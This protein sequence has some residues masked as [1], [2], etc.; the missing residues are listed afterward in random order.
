VAL[1][2]HLST[3]ALSSI[4][5][6]LN[7]EQRSIPLPFDL[8]MA[9]GVAGTS[10]VG[11]LLLSRG[12]QLLDASKAAAINFTQVGRGRGVGGGEVAGCSADRGRRPGG[13]SDD[14]NSPP[15]LAVGARCER[16]CCTATFLA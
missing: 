4:P 15:A 2:Y 8:G 16:R 12:F 14:R 3:L 6:A 13:S 7:W 10:F 9:L 5:L 1:W 11:Q